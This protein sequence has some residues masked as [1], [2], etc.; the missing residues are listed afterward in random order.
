MP[1]RYEVRARSKAD[2]DA[3]FDVLVH[4]GTWPTWSPI[5]ASDAGPTDR[6]RVGDSR[7]FRTGRNVSRETIM[8]LVPGKRFGYDN[9][10]GGVFRSYHAAVDLT[11]APGGGTDIAWSAEFEPRLPLTGGFW[12]WYLTRFMQRMADGLADYAYRRPG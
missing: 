8:E 10:D 2:P 11:P 1:Y 9:V 6:Q 5:D 7:V 12:R 4:A 3:V